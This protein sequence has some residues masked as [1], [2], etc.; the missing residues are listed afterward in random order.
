MFMYSDK[1]ELSEVAGALAKNFYHS[2]RTCNIDYFIEV[3]KG[4][5]NPKMTIEMK[6]FFIEELKS[7]YGCLC[8]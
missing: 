6:D 4:E 5:I 1:K 2:K 3:V 8:T 7:Q